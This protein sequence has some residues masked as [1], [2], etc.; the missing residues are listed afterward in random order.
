MIH[1][2]ERL[3]PKYLESLPETCEGVPL[4]ELETRI[5]ADLLENRRMPFRPENVLRKAGWYKH[6]HHLPAGGIEL[7]ARRCYCSTESKEICKQ[8]K[9]VPASEQLP[10]IATDYDTNLPAAF[11]NWVCN[12]RAGKDP[13]GDFIRDTRGLLRAGQSPG[14]KMPGA[15]REAVQEYVRLRTRW[16]AELGIHP[17]DC[18]PLNGRKK[19]S[20]TGWY[21]CCPECISC[22]CDGTGC[23]CGCGTCTGQEC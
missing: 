7:Q 15:S 16:A 14:Q 17:Q 9:S 2:V 12:R 11:W 18:S 3:V 4:E 21:H 6:H 8:R 10:Q 20:G 23:S 13:N 22:N 1:D 5:R 19:I